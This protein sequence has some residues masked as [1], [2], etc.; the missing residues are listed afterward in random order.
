MDS[1]PRYGSWETETCVAEGHQQEGHV[2]G[3]QE[4]AMAQVQDRSS[5]GEVVLDMVS[6]ALVW[7]G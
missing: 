2:V 5:A 3:G 7:E 1:G 6:S 4:G